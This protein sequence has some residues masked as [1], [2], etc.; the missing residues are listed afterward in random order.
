MRRLLPR[1]R[2]LT[3]TGAGGVGK[4]RLALRVARA[5]RSWFPDGVHVVELST[6]EEGRLLVPTVA[7]A[8]GIREMD[9]QAMPLLVAR[10]A[11]KRM[12]LLLDGCEHLLDC[13]TDLV[14]RLL[15]GAPRLRIM[16]TSRHRLGVL[17]EHVLPISSLP[18]ADRHAPAREIARCEAVRLFTDRAGIVCPGFRVTSANAPIVARISQRLDGIPLAIELAAARLRATPLDR[19]LGELDDRFA[20][21]TD[22]DSDAPPRQ[23]TLRATID[24]SHGLCSPAERRLWARLATFPG[25]ADLDTAE[26]VCPGGEIGRGEIFDL[27]AGLVDKSVLIAERFPAGLR[28]RMLDSIRA[29][30]RER[31]TGAEKERLRGR[32][33][34]HYRSLVARCRID[35]MTPD[36]L[37]RFHA[38]QLELPNLRAAMETCYGRPA[39]APAGLEVASALWSFWLLAGALTEGRHWL[40]RGLRLVPAPGRA[41]LTALWADALLALHQRDLAAAVIR[42]EECRA[43]AGETGDA[44]AAAFATMV[45]GIAA[46]AAGDDRRGL[47]LMEQAR[48]RHWEDGDLN[49]VGINLY[50]A[51]TFCVA[52][53]PDL[54]AALGEELV[55]LCDARDAP[56]FRAYALFAVGIAAWKQGD[57]RQAEAMMLQVAEPWSVIEDRWGLAQFLEVLAWTASAGGAQERA[58]RLLGAA[59]RVWH[60]LG[61]SPTQLPYHVRSHQQCETH[62]REALGSRA[63]AREFRAGTRLDLSAAVADALSG[64]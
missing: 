55:A 30:G 57:W 22:G 56:L 17:G 11:D 60:E 53:D 58:A 1:T 38:L 41:R 5:V 16:A 25:G 9:G 15:R 61:F 47:A 20:V 34:S 29:Y 7:A 27:I 10:L 19:L 39:S 50:L 48:R 14:D 46:L 62:A 23:Q 13:C 2:L 35:Q 4:T 42:I 37:D 44:T 28:Y 63:F 51:S 6:L 8:V 40:E 3:L 33:C 18:V 64:R 32:Y 49:A 21:L 36:Q 12:L 24:W 59:D 31:L 26:E 45:S 43:L 54:G 52:K